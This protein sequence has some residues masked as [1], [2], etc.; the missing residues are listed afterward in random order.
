[1]AGGSIGNGHT[2]ASNCISQIFV[3]WRRYDLQVSGSPTW[4]PRSE[5]VLLI[6]IQFKFIL[7]ATRYL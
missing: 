6:F 2:L 1:M 5:E 4:S 3:F 7:P